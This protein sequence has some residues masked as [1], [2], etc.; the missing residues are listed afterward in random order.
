MVVIDAN[1][2]LL[3]L[4]PDAGVPVGPDG[5]PVA[6][7]K[8]RIEFLTRELEKAK[9]KIVIPTPVLGEALVSAGPAASQKI[10]E[11]I[12]KYA[13]FRIEPFDTRAAIEVAAM[14]H[15]ALDGGKKRGAATGPWQKVK[16]DRQIVAIAKVVKATAIYSDDDDIRALAKTE[17]IP[18]LGVADLPIPE[19]KRQG[20]LPLT[21]REPV[22][23]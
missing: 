10:V 12:N 9:I 14:T 3:L 19:D 7:A 17:G 20:E 13:A 15:T 11:E 1:I 2:L 6:Y 8:E 5:K 22:E 16:I 21:P 23:D 18:V 4:R